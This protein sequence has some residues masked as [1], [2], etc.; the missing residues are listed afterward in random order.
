M[1]LKFD[2]RFRVALLFLTAILMVGCSL[3]PLKSGPASS[4]DGSGNGSSKTTTAFSPS[5]DAR[6]DL[7]DALRK[8][9]TSYPYRLTETMSATANVG[10]R[11]RLLFAVERLI[12]PH[13]GRTRL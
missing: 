13:H 2:L 6:K 12:F 10:R 11:L 4:S 5:N 1:T 7:G 9:N 3:T 8:L